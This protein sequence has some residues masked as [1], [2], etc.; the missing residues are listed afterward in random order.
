MLKRERLAIAIEDAVR[1]VLPLAEPL[2]SEEARSLHAL[3]WETFLPG[4]IPSN[5]VYEAI[6]T[7][8]LNVPRGPRA[9][10]IY[11]QQTPSG[12]CLLSEPLFPAFFCGADEL[13]RVDALVHSL[14]QIRAL[15]SRRSD[16]FAICDD[17]LQW[18]IVA[19]HKGPYFL[20]RL[21]LD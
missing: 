15:P 11:E 21:G 10:N 16:W 3:W 4:L 19:A 8:R 6:Q 20:W 5:P 18:S 12:V 1:S 14:G 2:P 9:D 13:P 17:E 7:L